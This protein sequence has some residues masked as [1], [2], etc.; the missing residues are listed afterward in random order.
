MSLAE[1]SRRIEQTS[2]GTAKAP[3]RQ[4]TDFRSILGV[5][6]PWRWRFLGLFAVVVMQGLS[7][8][9]DDPGLVAPGAKVEE[10]KGGFEFTEG[11]S[12][13]KNGDVYFSDIPK[14]R[15]HKWSAKDGTIS[16]FR[17]NSGSANGLCFD[18]KGS[19]LACEGGNGRVTSID[20]SG[21]VTVV[22]D[23]F[24]GKPFNSPNDLWVDAKGGVYFTDPRYG[25]EKNLPQPT[26]QVYYVS[27]D[28]KRVLRVTDDLTR[29][30]GIIGKKDGKTLYIADHGASKIYVYS[31]KAD[32]T[33]EGKRLFAPDGSDGM[34]L[35]ERGN[36]Y[37]T[38]DKIVVYDPAGK[39]IQEIV[40]PQVPANLTFAGPDRKTLFITAQK[41]VYSLKMNVRGQ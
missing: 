25:D 16:I 37:L 6:A 3:R 13:D 19:L 26:Q 21:K 11:P 28:R 31:I 23:K 24:S 32:G 38:T 29:P 34:K 8:A 36:V 12:A 9:A 17:E 10:I 27:A 4:G 2:L 7:L 41:S 39:K 14:S 1:P 22:A 30:N 33:L 20:M 15:I 18:A 35:D 40:L 5:L